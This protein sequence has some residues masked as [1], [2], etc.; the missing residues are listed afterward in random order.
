MTFIRFIKKYGTHIIVGIS[1]GG[2]DLVLVKQE[3]SSKLDSSQLGKHLYDLGDQL[4]TGTCR[5]T[6]HRKSKENRQK[7]HR[8]YKFSGASTINLIF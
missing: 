3:K 1:I 7:V 4:F 5:F 2:Q 8:V 6:P